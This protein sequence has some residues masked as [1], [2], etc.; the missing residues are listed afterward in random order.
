MARA[1]SLA[2]LLRVRHAQQQKAMAELSLA[3]QRVRD[4][5]ERRAAATRILESA[6]GSKDVVT[7]AATLTA[8]AAARA[9]TRGMLAELDAMA[10]A[11][12]AAASDAQTAYNEARA[13]SIALEKLEERHGV[14]AAAEELRVEQIAL[15]EIANS[16]PSSAPAPSLE[17]GAS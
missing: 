14:A 16:R 5:A 6:V 17:G 4:V 11:H 10:S 3:N 12:E 7:D 8:I 2:G 9:S 15:D 13:R 1:F